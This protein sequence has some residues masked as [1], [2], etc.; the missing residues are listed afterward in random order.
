MYKPGY[1]LISVNFRE[2][3]SSKGKAIET[4]QVA[5][6]CLEIYIILHIIYHI[7]YIIL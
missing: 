6:S 4:E 7:L 2:G 3:I 5:F 1:L